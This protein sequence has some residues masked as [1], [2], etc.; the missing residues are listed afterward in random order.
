MASHKRATRPKKGWRNI[1]V[2][3]NLSLNVSENI[4]WS[5]L[6][7]SFPWSPHN[8]NQKGRYFSLKMN[9]NAVVEEYVAE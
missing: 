2:E 8:I 6:G 1:A 4:K 3:H 7:D 5:P 9:E